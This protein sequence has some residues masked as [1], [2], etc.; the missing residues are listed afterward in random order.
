M[1]ECV[2]G[3][4]PVH[5]QRRHLHVR[6]FGVLEAPRRAVSRR[7]SHWA[8]SCC[9]ATDVDK[10]RSSRHGGTPQIPARCHQV[11]VALRV[12]EGVARATGAG[13]A[14]VAAAWWG[15]R[16][17]FGLSHFEHHL[18]VWTE[19]HHRY[20]TVL[21]S[22]SRFILKHV[23]LYLVVDGGTDLNQQETVGDDRK[24]TQDGGEEDRQP[25]DGLAQGISGGS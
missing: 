9:G 6:G 18:K 7:S 11:S 15:G 5:L 12:R 2:I 3:E 8:E 24:D 17:R 16:G 21:S 20:E 22:R 10:P 25:N 14:D 23:G 4:T 13:A 19:S 1:S